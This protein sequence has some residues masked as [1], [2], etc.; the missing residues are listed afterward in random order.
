MI[1]TE[2]RD[3]ILADGNPIGS[4]KERFDTARGGRRVG[5]ELLEQFGDRFEAM[6]IA[7]GGGV[8]VWTTTK[9]WCIRWEPG[10]EKLIYLPRN[11]PGHGRAANQT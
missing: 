8:V 5:R 3:F 4:E 7:D 10:L 11:P 6:E 9:V 1:T 2:W